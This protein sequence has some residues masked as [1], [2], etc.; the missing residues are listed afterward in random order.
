MPLTKSER[1]FLD[2]YVYGATHEPF[3]GPTTSDLRRLGIYY[4]D[5]NWILTAFDR[6]LRALG[7]P[8]LGRQ[9]SSPP[10]SPWTDRTH[11]LVRN[12]EL[13]S[14]WEGQVSDLVK[15]E[16][17]ITLPQSFPIGSTNR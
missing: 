5:L 8:P 4:S 7:I 17:A 6:E 2:A 11:A 12:Q 10:P 16:S 13:R 14:E 3:G 1:D 15:S 9:N